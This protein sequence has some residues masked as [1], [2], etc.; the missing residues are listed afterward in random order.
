[1][2]SE[3]KSNLIEISELLEAGQTHPV[4][5][6]TFALKEIPVAFGYIDSGR[7]KGNTVVVIPA[8]GETKITSD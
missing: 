3:G 1:M 2:A 7:R 8:A 5:D 6:R 4:I